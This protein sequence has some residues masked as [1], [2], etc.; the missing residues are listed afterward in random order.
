MKSKNETVWERLPD[1]SSQAFEAFK[2]F[3]DLGDKRTQSA[4]ALQ[5]GKSVSLMQ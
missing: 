2:T 1:E 4:V 3:R 5:L